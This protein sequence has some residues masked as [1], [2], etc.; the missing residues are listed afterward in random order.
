MIYVGIMVI[1]GL[2]R[3]NYPY[4]VDGG[5]ALSGRKSCGGVVPGMPIP[6]PNTQWSPRR[7]TGCLL[8]SKR[9]GAFLSSLVSNLGLIY[10]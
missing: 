1:A 2:G 8:I 4:P 5:F 7:Y 3:I 9:L 10:E 6:F